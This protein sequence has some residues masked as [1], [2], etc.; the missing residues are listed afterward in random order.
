MDQRSL[1]HGGALRA[2]PCAHLQRAA[3][4]GLGSG[5]WGD[6]EDP[7]KGFVSASSCSLAGGW[8]DSNGVGEPISRKEAV[9]GANWGEVRGRRGS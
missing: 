6:L 1:P 8:Y 5:G 2:S 3:G 9:V 4:M 7:E